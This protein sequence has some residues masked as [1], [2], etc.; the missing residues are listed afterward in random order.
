MSQLESHEG[1]IT[2]ELFEDLSVHL[3]ALS[4]EHL[5]EVTT[6]LPGL[7]AEAA[8]LWF[9]DFYKA[10]SYIEVE[11]WGHGM[12]E[13]DIEEKFLTIGTTHRKKEKENTTA[14]VLGEKGI[15]RL[16]CMRL[17][18]TLE[19]T[20]TTA[21]ESHWATLVVDW[22][23]LANNLDM[24]LDNFSVEVEQGERKESKGRSGTRIRLSY[25]EA[26]W[27]RRRVEI[28]VV[29]EFAKLQDPFNKKLERLQLEVSFNERPVSIRWSIDRLWLKRWH[30]HFTIA[31]TYPVIDGKSSNRS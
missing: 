2:P 23:E 8:A 31:L 9:K 11:D 13:A 21:K 22:D 4:D 25:L 28:L 16:S 27:D 14:T 18:R 26:D 5:E 19:L 17:A 24:D 1:A 7:D 10:I 20:S 30:G 6:N 12:S 3:T 15:G 29:E